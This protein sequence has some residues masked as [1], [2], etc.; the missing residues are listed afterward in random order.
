[1]SV[2]CNRFVTV[3]THYHSIVVTII[4]LNTSYEALN[5]FGLQVVSAYAKRFK[6]AHKLARY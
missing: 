5:S 4:A 3:N 1:M 6:R 2:N